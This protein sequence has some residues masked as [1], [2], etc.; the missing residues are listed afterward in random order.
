MKGLRT[1]H[2]INMIHSDIKPDNI[3]YSPFFEKWVFLDF[4]MSQIV[5]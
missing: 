3:S 4:G 1:I 5:Q 2:Q